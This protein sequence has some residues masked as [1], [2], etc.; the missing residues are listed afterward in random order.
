MTIDENNLNI[1]IEQTLNLHGMDRLVELIAD[2]L[3]E[4]YIDGHEKGFT[5]GYNY[6]INEEDYHD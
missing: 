2:M 4:Y 3:E 6:R 5:S 1:L